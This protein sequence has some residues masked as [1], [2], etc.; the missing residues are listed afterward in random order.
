MS[1]EEVVAQKMNAMQAR[2]EKAEALNDRMRVMVAEEKI[3]RNVAERERDE[4]RRDFDARTADLVQV[5]RERVKAL[6]E[7]WRLNA[8][9]GRPLVGEELRLCA[10]ELEAALEGVKR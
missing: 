10:D 2:A 6:V 7:R 1:V 5:E 4:A 3:Q 9:M 8:V